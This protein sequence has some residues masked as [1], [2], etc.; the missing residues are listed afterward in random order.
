VVAV[1][2]SAGFATGDWVYLMSDEEPYH[3]PY[4]PGFLR[5]ITGI[6]TNTVELDIPVHR[7]CTT[8]RRMVKVNLA[9]P[10]EMLWTGAIR[11][12]DW[13][14]MGPNDY[15]IQQMHPI[16]F[17]LC[18]GLH[19]GLP[20]E[21]VH[22]YQTGA[23]FS[24]AASVGGEIHLN[25]HHIPDLALASPTIAHWGYGLDEQGGRQITYHL[26][27]SYTRHG[28]TTQ[29]NTWISSWPNGVDQIQFHGETEHCRFVY[30]VH[31]TMSTGVNTH[32]GGWN[33]SHE[34]VIRDTGMWGDLAENKQDP[35]GLF[36]RAR[37]DHVGPAGL[38]LYNIATRT[39]TPW[40]AAVTTAEKSPAYPRVF[41]LAEGP[42]YSDLDLTTHNTKAGIRLK[43]PSTIGP[44]VTIQA[45][46]GYPGIVV[47]A[48]AD[49]SRIVGPVTV[50]GGSAPI[51][52]AQYVSNSGA[53]TWIP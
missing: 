39:A 8:N 49:G 9:P 41:T 16:K 34:G 51:V 22:V 44:R 18:A 3:K 37:R 2:S 20:G 23:G 10:I 38:R 15:F 30:N 46:P 50:R 32:E 24:V 45:K 52:G 27:S 47:E 6:V 25:A 28:M 53:I 17:V 36:F 1:Q 13:I 12:R 33:N 31:E 14:G 4:R 11:H 35:T 29:H 5:R 7:T 40:Y 21:P 48:A 19:L 26:E 42:V 43:Q